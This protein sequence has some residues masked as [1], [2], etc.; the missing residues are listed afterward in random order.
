VQERRRDV[1]V[2]ILEQ[3]SRAGPML[4]QQSVHLVV[5]ADLGLDVV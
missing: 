5:D 2:E 1:R 3:P 4:A